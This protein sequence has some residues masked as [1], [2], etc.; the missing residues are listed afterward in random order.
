ML[1]NPAWLEPAV[2]QELLALYPRQTEWKPRRSGP[3]H[4]A[5]LKGADAA[6]LSVQLQIESARNPFAP[7][8]G[9]SRFALLKAPEGCEI[10]PHVDDT[11][12]LVGHRIVMLQPAK[13]GGILVVEDV[14]C[15][16]QPGDSCV[17]D[18]NRE[19]HWVTRVEGC[20]R[21]VLSIQR[22]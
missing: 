3:Y 20:E 15:P 17:F 6:R 2:V 10:K 22:F 13:A 14:P 8:R 18:A 9:T 5:L 11:P 7:A 12:G 16:L 19:R 4:G 21:R 1:L